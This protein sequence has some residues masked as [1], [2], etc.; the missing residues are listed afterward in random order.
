MSDGE[1]GWSV[2]FDIIGSRAPWGF[3]ADFFEGQLDEPTQL[4]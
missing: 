3:S 2:I 4:H 1:F